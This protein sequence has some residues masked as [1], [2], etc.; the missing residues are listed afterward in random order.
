MRLL[1]TFALSA[2]LLTGACTDQYG[3]PDPGATLGLVAGAAALGGV[4]Y[5]ATRNHDDRPRFRDR[6]YGRARGY[7]ARMD[8]RGE[9][10]GY[11]R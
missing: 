1:T 5:L 9:R 7:D 2:A 11:G 4:A 10:R 6:G 8:Y 3:N